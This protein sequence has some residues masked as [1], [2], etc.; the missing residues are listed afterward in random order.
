[1]VLFAL[2]KRLQKKAANRMTMG[3]GDY[4]WSSPTYQGL[5]NHGGGNDSTPVDGQFKEATIRICSVD[6]PL[7]LSKI[8]QK[9][10][11]ERQIRVEESNPQQKRKRG[12]MA[13]RFK[14]PS[15]ATQS[16]AMSRRI[17]SADTV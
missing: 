12:S 7:L 11:S 16:K 9:A 2:G 15:A 10:N 3:A 6:R 14:S 4:S 8:R 5:M 17:R 13:W 1:M